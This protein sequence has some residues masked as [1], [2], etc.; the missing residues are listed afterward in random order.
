MTN[1]LFISVHDFRSL[2]KASIHFIAAECAR[3]GDVR[4]FSIGLSRLSE[5][6]GDTRANLA[7]RANRVEQQD[8]VACYLWRQSWHPFSLRHRRLLPLERALFRL[9]RLMLP[10]TPRRWLREADIVFIESGMAPVFIADVRRLNPH[11]RIIYLASDDLETVGCAR[12]IRQDFARHYDQI[13]TVRLPSRFLADGMPHLRNAILV[14][15]G[16]DRSIASGRYPDPYGGGTACVSVGS[17]LFDA[18]FF[19]IAAPLFPALSFH[20][21]GAGKAASRLAAPNIVIHPEMAFADTLPYL[22]HAAFGIAPYRD[23]STPRYLIDTSL[24]LRQFGLFG[25][26]AVC[27]DFA[28]GG[29]PGRFGYRPGDAGSIK[30]AIEAA[31]ANQHPITDI[32]PSWPDVVDRILTPGSF[33]DIRLPA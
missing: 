11:A 30:Q 17:M 7:D 1:F 18:S 15:H 4:F 13:D 5:R 25:L 33:P 19:A 6:R 8:G 14:P 3:R 21:I 16:I 12:T 9:Y 2:R 24:K 27:P 32:S 20:V 23:A 26:P 28:T 29:A 22:Q 10:S 31:L